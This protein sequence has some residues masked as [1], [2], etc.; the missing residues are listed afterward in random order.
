VM[1]SKMVLETCAAIYLLGVLIEFILKRNWVRVSLE[2]AAIMIVVAGALLLNNSVNGIVSLGEGQSQLVPILIMFGAI[3]LGVVARYFFYLTPGQFSWL[4]LLKP[5]M[6][7]PIVLI[8][9]MSSVQTMS[10]LNAMQLASFGLLAFQN[11]F[12]WQAVLDA[13]RPST[14]TAGRKP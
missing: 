5:T 7:S 1:D 4:G 8:P 14:K 6:I 9:L 3:V 12:F 10:N 13:A 11:G 2:L